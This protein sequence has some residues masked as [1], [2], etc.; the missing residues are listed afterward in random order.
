VKALIY[1]FLAVV[2]KQSGSSVSGFDDK[3]RRGSEEY[4]AF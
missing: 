4:I 3:G 2:K 1:K